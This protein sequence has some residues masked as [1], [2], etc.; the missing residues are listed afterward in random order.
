MVQEPL[1][2]CY[3]FDN[4]HHALY[5]RISLLPP[6]TKQITLLHIDQ[7]SDLNTPETPLDSNKITDLDYLR[8][9]AN[10]RC[11]I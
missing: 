5:F 2:H 11:T 4:H 1:P 8:D 3:I 6:T 7:H 9:Y 10:L